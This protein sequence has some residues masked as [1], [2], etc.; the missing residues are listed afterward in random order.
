MMSPFG[1]GYSPFGF[2]PFGYGFGFGIPGPILLLAV[3]GLALTSFRSSRGIDASDKAGAALCLQVSAAA[4]ICLSHLPASCICSP[5]S[6]VYLRTAM[7]HTQAH[8]QLR[9]CCLA[10]AE[11]RA[12][13]TRAAAAALE[14]FRRGAPRAASL[15]LPTS[16][17][18]DPDA[19][20]PHPPPPPPPPG[21]V[22]LQRPL[23]L[24]LRSP[25]V[26][27][28]RGGDAV[29]RGPAAPRLGLVRRVV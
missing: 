4:C 7:G 15:F 20:R 6:P 12:L 19:H 17:A 3:G 27:R 22:L 9:T 29:V 14:P 24:A 8:H 5:V 16:P 23:R 1:F 18:P 26:R 10:N 25:P 2:S 21:C 11:A 13:T 28:S